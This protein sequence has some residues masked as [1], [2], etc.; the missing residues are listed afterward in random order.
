MTVELDEERLL[1]GEPYEIITNPDLGQQYRLLERGSDSDGEYLRFEL[2]YREDSKH[3]PGHVHPSYDETAAVLSGGIFV[4]TAEEERTVGAGEQYTIPAGTP[5]I[6][7]TASGA[8]TRALIEERPPGDWVPYMRMVCGLAQD[9]K[10][11]GEGIPNPLAGAVLQ[12]AYPDVAYSAALP[13]A[14]QKLLF[15][16]LAPVGRLRGYSA[17]YPAV[18][19]TGSG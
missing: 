11:D 7:R 4:R 8:E 2:R 13:I 16:L 18:H 1:S 14:V 5:H 17:D 3:F 19:H 15:K 10:T 12:D 9:G 6:H